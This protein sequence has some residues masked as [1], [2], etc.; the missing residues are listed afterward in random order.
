MSEC[1]VVCRVCR[2][3][4]RPRRWR[5]LCE[6]CAADLRIQHLREF[7]HA[8]QVSQELT[9]WALRAPFLRERVGAR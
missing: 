8:T 6:E 7:G 5:F 4:G 9:Q 2:V 3:D 1:V